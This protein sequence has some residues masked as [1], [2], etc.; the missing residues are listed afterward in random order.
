MNSSWRPTVFRKIAAGVAI[1]LGAAGVV[2]L[3][4]YFGLLDQSELQTYDWRMRQAY[5]AR[6]GSNPFPINPDIVLVEINDASIRDF[7]PAFGRW[8]WPRAIH[9]MLVDYLSRG[10]PKAIAIDVIFAEPERSSTYEIAGQTWSSRDS[11]QALVD[12]VKRAGNVVLLADAV[13][14]GLLGA[15]NPP[16]AEWAA[17]PYRLDERVEARPVITLPFPALADA[18]ATFGQDFLLIDPDGPVRRVT[19]FVRQRQRY[20]PFLGLAAVLL[21]EKY[22]PEEVVFESDAIRV[23]NGRIPLVKSRVRTGAGTRDQWTM[24]INYRAP[25]QDENARRP[26][27]TYEARYL[28][29]SEDAI[30]REE[31]PVVDP[32]VFKDKIVL[33][34]LNAAGLVDVFQTPHGDPLM[35]GIQVHASVADSVLSH[36]YIRPASHWTRV[37]AAMGGAVAIGLASASLPF[38]A[39][40]VTAVL[41]A[42]AWTW[43]SLFLFR[44]GIWVNLT[45]PVLAVA[46]ALFAG[47]AYRY[48]VEDREK[49]KVKRLFGRYVSKDV[50]SQLIANP[51]LAELGG[52]RRDMT[53]LFSDIRG[54]TSVTEKGDP[55]ELVA[56]L[57]EYFTRMVDI[58]FRHRGTVD[59]FVGDMVMALFSAPL[60]DGDHAEH[61]VEAAIEM[62]RE[63]GELNRKWLGEGRAQLDIGVGINSGE[64]IAG[65]IGSSAIMSYTVIGDNVNLGSRLESLNKDYKTR[66]IISDATRARLKGSYA[67]RPLGEVV[68]KGK[69]R[70]VAIFEVQVPSPLPP[71]VQPG[72]RVTVQE[73]T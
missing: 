15:E 30:L 18:A 55:E 38:S 54:F 13:H 52:Q 28:L 62:V 68:V 43:L 26:F 40:A 63:L 6:A 4:G 1:G 61:A 48:F 7:A 69:T 19:P 24:L 2:L 44:E 35:P 23:R 64:M 21:A 66:V 45:T 53:V 10:K 47:T 57:N 73:G 39:A 37:A 32:A 20:M 16:D 29:A 3:L 33:V 59:K 46:V 36:L 70:P 42:A 65:N 60:D 72:Q 49:R 51:E 25:R 56:Q 9:A 27:T 31:K 50:Y 58:V 41:A 14:P 67:I 17:P 12:S 8:P 5:R 11:D 22:K 71:A 34:G